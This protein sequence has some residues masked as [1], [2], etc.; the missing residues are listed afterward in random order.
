MVKKIA[1]VSFMPLLMCTAAAA[2]IGRTLAFPGA[3]GFGAY[4]IGGR[5]GSV[6]KVTNLSDDG[7]GSLRA[8]LRSEGPRTVI[9]ETSGII[10]LESS[11]VL[12]SGYVTIAG[13]TAPGS[14]ITLKNHGLV[15]KANEVIIRY[16]RSRP[17]SEKGVE[18]DA[19]SVQAGNNII[20]DH[21]ST[22]WAT[23]ETLSVSPSRKDGLRT[24]DNVTVQWSMITE[25]L[26]KSVHSKGQHGYGSLV[27]GS[28]G[29]RFSLHHNLWAHHKARMPRPGNYIDAGMDPQGP[30]FDFRNN[31]FYNWGGAASGYNADTESVSHYN[32][33]NNYYQRGPDTTKS[34]AFD[35]SNTLAVAHFSGNFMDGELPDNPWDLVRFK[36]GRKAGADKPF[37]VASVNTQPADEAFEDVL[38][39]AGASLVRDRVD[40]RVV[41]DTRSKSGR[42]INHVSQVGGWPEPVK[43]TV[44]PDTD[45]DGLPDEWELSRGLNIRDASDGNGD[46]DDDGYT[47]LEEYL[48]SLV[49]EPARVSGQATG[50]DQMMPAEFNLIEIERPRILSKAADYLQ[51]KPVTVTAQ[52]AERSEGGVHDFFS[53]GD[54]WWPDPENPDGP[55]IR[56]DGMSNPDNFVGHRRAMVRLS[57]IIGTLSSAFIITGDA[58]YADHSRDHLAA[59]F[60]DEST[61]MNP[62]LLYGQAIKGRFSGRSIGIIDTIHL[63]EVARGAKILGEAGALPTADFAAIKVWFNEY[64]DWLVTHPYGQRERVHPNNHG[65]CWSMQVAVF[66]DLVGRE[67]ELDWIRNQFK[68]IY[69]REMMAGDGS[70]PEELARTKPYGYSLFVLDAMAMVAQVASAPE[71]DLWVFELPDGRGMAKGMSFLFPYMQDKSLWPYKKDVLYWD[72]WPVR[73]PSLLLAGLHFENPDYLALWKSLKADPGTPEV[74]RNLPIRHPLLW[75]GFD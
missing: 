56:R 30:L 34:L 12:K 47:N 69:L 4:T 60:I 2:D 7:P 44:D 25:S 54:Y 48:N 28:A 5:G 46:S 35:E 67:T 33:V 58:R 55:Y 31:V 49:A 40:L 61:R 15:I 27:R 18:T 32:F 45:G 3:E 71:D 22:S 21:C 37:P 1:L 73:H 24:I 6:L 70:F 59:W 29:A 36:D 19:I 14:G 75:V 50:A 39:H 16:L 62:S 9:F 8:A 68:T 74:L 11:I 64:L 20:I 17:G 72:E 63:A 38:R 26:N 53:E 51:A 57:E 13:Q 66:A 43:G 23:D 42:L 41:T 65:V 52:R 10:E